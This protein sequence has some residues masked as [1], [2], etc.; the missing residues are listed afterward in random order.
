MGAR[1]AN[2]AIGLWMFF[3]PFFW[4]HTPFQRVNAWVVGVI[5]VTAALAAARGLRW[6]R[7]VNAA[8]GGWLIITALLPLGQRPS[9]IW[10]QVICGFLLAV[11]AMPRRPR[12][13]RG[14]PSHP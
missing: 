13:L 5:A 8:L 3:T 10:N 9:I 4:F 1:A 7:L 12:E 6:A 2:A 11:F 14:Q